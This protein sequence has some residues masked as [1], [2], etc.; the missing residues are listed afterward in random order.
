MPGAGAEERWRFIHDGL[1]RFAGRALALDDEVY[2]SASETNH[3]NQSIARLLQSYGRIVL[4]SGR[5]RRPVH[6]AVLA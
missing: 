2:A 3:R 4:R 5:G 1:S 6:A